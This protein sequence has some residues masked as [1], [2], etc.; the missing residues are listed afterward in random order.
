VPEYAEGA[1]K[2]M[3]THANWEWEIGRTVQTFGAVTQV[4]SAYASGRELRDP[5]PIARGMNS[6][7]LFYDGTRWY[8]VTIYWAAEHGDLKIPSQYLNQK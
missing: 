1:A 6:F 4:F 2:Y 3:L 7:Q 8:I 5:Q